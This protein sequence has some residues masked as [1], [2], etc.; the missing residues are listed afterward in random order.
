MSE[1]TVWR[2]F[3]RIAGGLAIVATMGSFLASP[4]D[5]AGRIAV[6]VYRC[7]AVMVLVVATGFL[8]ATGPAPKG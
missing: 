4:G 1:Q 2:G 3:L 8:A 7:G 5:D 6:A